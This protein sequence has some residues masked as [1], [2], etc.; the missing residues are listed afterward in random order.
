MR[1]KFILLLSF[2]LCLF[3]C[4]CNYDTT[5][6]EQINTTYEN[7]DCIVESCE[8][9]YWYASGAHFK[10]YV[11]VRNEEYNLEENFT[12]DGSDAKKCENLKNGDTISCTIITRTNQDGNVL[13]RKIGH[14]N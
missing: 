5:D 3:L 6:R 4:S 7:M 12:L 13:D 10:A 9:Q 11:S 14:I 2:I 1:K 8:Y